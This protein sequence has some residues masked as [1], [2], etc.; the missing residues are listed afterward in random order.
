MMA[1]T[2]NGVP[3]RIGPKALLLHE[4]LRRRVHVCG[5]FPHFRIFEADL[6]LDGSDALPE[7][8]Q[9]PELRQSD[10]G[11]LSC[12]ARNPEPA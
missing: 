7:F 12:D 9:P 5:P 11:D 1:G 8:R 10:R 4:A 3:E 6:H 2:A